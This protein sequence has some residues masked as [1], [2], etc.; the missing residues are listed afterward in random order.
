MI[1]NPHD[2]VISEDVVSIL[3]NMEA[4]VLSHEKNSTRPNL[5][6]NILDQIHQVLNKC[7]LA[8]L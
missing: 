5:L 3:E 8:A 2:P 1:L 4:D 6:K 7:S